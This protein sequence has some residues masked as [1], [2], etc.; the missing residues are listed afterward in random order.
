MA[1]TPAGEVIGHVPCTRGYVGELPVLGLGPLRVRPDY[2][3]RGVG[4]ALVHTV[5]G[6]ADALGEPLVALPG[7]PAYYCRFGFRLAAD[8]DVTP[9]RPNWGRHFQVRPAE[10]LR[11]VG[12]RPVH[13]PRTLRP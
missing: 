11:A 5:L 13:L 8:C 9:P 3:R 2:Q 7:D 1:V 6:A 12:R 10:R 4:S